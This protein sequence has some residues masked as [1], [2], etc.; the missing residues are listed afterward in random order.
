MELFS[1]FKALGRITIRDKN[2]TLASGIITELGKEQGVK[3]GIKSKT[4]S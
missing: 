3:G 4:K 1:N 2:Q